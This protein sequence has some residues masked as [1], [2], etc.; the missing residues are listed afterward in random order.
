MNYCKNCGENISDSRIYCS[1]KCRNIYVNKNIRDYT[2][3]GEGITNLHIEKYNNN[4]KFCKQCGEKIPYNKRD[5]TFCDNSCQGDYNTGIDRS[6][7]V[8]RKISKSLTG[9]VST[10]KKMIK[11]KDDYLKSPNLCL[12]CGSI[13]KYKYRHRKY[14]N[15]DCMSNFLYKNMS[16]YNRYKKDSS[17]TFSLNEYPDKFNFTL[18]EEY[19]WYSPSNSKKPNLNGISRDHM[20]SVNSGFKLGIDPKLIAHPANC[21]L[22]KHN[23]NVSKNNECSIT[24]EDLIERIKN[25]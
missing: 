6:D 19:G 25:W 21:K 20:F 1:L 22:M 15:K 11:L 2:K 16:E 8:K 5:N 3:N 24:Y 23:D 12:D 9:R 18:I 7:D 4:P 14:C 17:F 13:L 10:N